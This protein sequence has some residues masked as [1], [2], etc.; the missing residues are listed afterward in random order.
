MENGAYLQSPIIHTNNFKNAKWFFYLFPNLSDF[1]SLSLRNE[2]DDCKD[3]IRI[4]YM[5]EMIDPN[6]KILKQKYIPQSYF[7]TNSWQGPYSLMKI[8]ELKYHM[9]KWKTGTL[10][11][12][13]HVFDETHNQLPFFYETR[14]EIQVQKYAFD[15]NVTV[16]PYKDW[17]KKINCSFQEAYSFDITF[18][19]P[20][21]KI[22]VHIRIPEEQPLPRLHKLKISVLNKRGTYLCLQNSIYEFQPS[23]FEISFEKNQLEYVTGSLYSCSFTLACTIYAPAEYKE[24][25]CNSSFLE[26]ISGEELQQFLIQRRTLCDDLKCMYEDKKHSDVKLRSN[27]EIMQ[28]HKC[29]L[30][31]RS[32]VFSA[33]FDHDMVENQTGIVDIFDVD[34]E[35]LR[36]LMEFLYTDTINI[37]DYDQTLKLILVADKY[38]VNILKDECSKLLMS[39]LSPH[40]ACEV[41]S[42]AEMIHQ[43]DLKYFALDYIKV[44]KKL[45]LSLPDWTELVDKNKKLAIEILTKLSIE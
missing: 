17:S 10:E 37:T 44:N 34:N 36:A 25:V 30:S 32:S 7:V 4:S 19:A 6:G 28:V 3:N 41:I 31:A 9:E 40:N 33:M 26:N 14:T 23:E 27:N 45:I 15:W 2:F 38:E 29:L 12:C 21:K 1:I 42:V 11:I 5:L 43:K 13:C 24:M 18:T 16:P 20:D 39:K 35:T 22:C 8:E